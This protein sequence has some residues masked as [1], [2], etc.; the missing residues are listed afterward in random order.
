MNQLMDMSMHDFNQILSSKAAAPGGGSTAALAGMLGAALTMMVVNLSIGKKAYAA[1]GENIH[2]QIAADHALIT[3]LNAELSELV[4]EDT[5]AFTL[6]MEAMQLPQ[7]TAAEQLQR[8]E[9]MQKASLYALDVPLRTAEK[10]LQVLQHQSNI[11]QY[12]NKNAVSDIGVG[13]EL[14]WA[15]LKGAILNVKINLP[16]IED[17]TVEMDAIDRIDRILTEGET[18]HLAITTIVERRI[19]EMLLVP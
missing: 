14:A 15:G 10:C 7:A 18:L 8:S 13:A 16:G 12:G 19:A 2:R 5:S 3:T 1:L 9:Q 4:D 17:Q 11:A 6:F